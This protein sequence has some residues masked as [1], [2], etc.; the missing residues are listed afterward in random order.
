MAGLW[1][2]FGCTESFSRGDKCLGS[3]LAEAS[4]PLYSLN[5]RARGKETCPGSKQT[6]L[7]IRNGYLATEPLRDAFGYAGSLNDSGVTGNEWAR[8]SWLKSRQETTSTGSMQRSLFLAPVQFS[9]ISSVI[10]FLRAK[11][12][13]MGPWIRFNGGYLLGMVY[14]QIQ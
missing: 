13:P 12:F 10:R 5:W 9:C 1:L 7:G 8:D 2:R 11:I 6:V 14:W 4:S 3:L